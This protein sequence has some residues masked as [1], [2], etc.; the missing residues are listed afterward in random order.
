[1]SPRAAAWLAWSLC[2]LTLILVACVVAFEALYRVSLSSLSLFVFVVSSAL[3]GTVVAS[4]QTR[5]PIGW[6]FVVSATCL[7]VNEATGRYAI[8]GLV[9]EPGSVPLAHLMAWP[10]TWMWLPGIALIIFFVPLYF[11]NGHLLSPR[12]RPVLWLALLFSVGF[13]VVFGAFFPGEMDE[14]SPGVAGDV[15]GIVNPLG[16]EALR[17][18]DRVTQVDIILTV[19]L[20]VIVL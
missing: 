4:R 5:N 6:L 13:G 1:M 3:V 11:P 18:L 14:L 2:G 12:W 10:S 20:L 16:I 8:Y 7:A 15:P 9:I 19:V 17:S